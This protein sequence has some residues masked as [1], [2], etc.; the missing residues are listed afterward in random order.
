M[1][2]TTTTSPPL[3]DRQFAFT[4]PPKP[5]TATSQWPQKPPKTPTNRF[6]NPQ[7]ASSPPSASFSRKRSRAVDEEGPTQERGLTLQSSPSRPIRAP[8][9]RERTPPSDQQT[10]T[11]P[12][13]DPFTTLPGTYEMTI[14]DPTFTSPGFTLTLAFAPPPPSF[15]NNPHHSSN[16]TH[17]QQNQQPQL[18]AAFNLGLLTGLLRFLRTP[19]F[20][21][22]SIPVE[23]LVRDDS[24]GNVER[25]MGE[26]RFVEDGRVLGRLEGAAFLIGGL[27]DGVDGVGGGEDMGRRIREEWEECVREER[28]EFVDAV[29]EAEMDEMDMEGW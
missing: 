26:V 13:F 5:T 1:S 2:A 16:N 23:I 14:P 17:Q 22:E 28:D 11:P 3:Q 7:P 20:L 25:D 6:S 4:S 10:T 12:T 8:K 27:E 19:R 9:R 21:P 15:S 24:G 29:L 18:W